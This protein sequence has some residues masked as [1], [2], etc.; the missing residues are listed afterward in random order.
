MTPI[1]PNS[2]KDTGLMQAKKGTEN[3]NKIGFSVPFLIFKSIL[4]TCCTGLP[5]MRWLLLRLWL[6]QGSGG[7]GWRSL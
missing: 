6:L 2:Y 1:P 5:P 4:I 3:L 7:A